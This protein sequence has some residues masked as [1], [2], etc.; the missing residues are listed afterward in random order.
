MI[1][2][3]HLALLKEGA[4]LVNCA[5]GPI[6]D[7]EA[8]A[9]LL[10]RGKIAAALDVFDTEPPLADEYVLRDVP[11][12]LLT[13]H[14]AFLTKEAMQRR[15]VIEFENVRAFLAGSIKNQCVL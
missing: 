10:K 8:L 4:L 1:D 12:S 7:S 2:A 3:E 6:V 14:V 9:Q 5:R 13:P 11:H 15:A